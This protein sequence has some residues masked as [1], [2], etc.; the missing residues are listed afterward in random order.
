MK[1]L[2]RQC[3]RFLSES[4]GRSTI[5]A[6]A[7]ETQKSEQNCRGTD[8][9]PVGR[10]QPARVVAQFVEVVGNPT[11][12]RKSKTGIHGF[13]GPGFAAPG[14]GEYRS[15]LASSETNNVPASGG[16]ATL[17]REPPSGFSSSKRRAA[18]KPR[19]SC[20]H[21]RS[22]VVRWR[23]V[24]RTRPPRP[25]GS[26][27]FGIAGGIEWG[28]RLRAG[29]GPTPRPRAE[30]RMSGWLAGPGAA[31]IIASPENRRAL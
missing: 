16:V 8:D 4:L 29:I 21:P 28:N 3:G 25:L 31:D 7:F 1:P 26:F 12:D 9:A 20:A 10:V 24:V 23:F 2:I 15:P 5:D 11:R 17:A 13:A 22:A 30:N 18:R 6:T 19:H 27:L 14:E